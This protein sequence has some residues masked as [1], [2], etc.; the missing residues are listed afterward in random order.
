MQGFGNYPVAVKLLENAN[1][2]QTGQPYLGS[3]KDLTVQATLVVPTGTATVVTDI[4]V[5]NDNIAWL[6]IATLTT[7]HAIPSEGF[8][9][10]ARWLY[11]RARIAS[12]D[13]TDNDTLL[14][15]T[16]VGV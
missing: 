6:R 2:V 5:S 10:A 14:T 1:G 12:W 15:V 9:T 16:L 7:Q 13:A 3:L 11:W 8:C 4:E